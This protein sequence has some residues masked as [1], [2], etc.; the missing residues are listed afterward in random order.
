[1]YLKLYTCFQILNLFSLY[2]I[3]FSVNHVKTI[4]CVWSYIFYCKW[5]WRKNVKYYTFTKKIGKFYKYIKLELSSG[6]LPTRGI[7]CM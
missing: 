6:A 1:M 7:T 2:N 5:H 3:L 4:E